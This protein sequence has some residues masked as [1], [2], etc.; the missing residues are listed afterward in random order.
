MVHN[1]VRPK[2]QYQSTDRPCLSPALGGLSVGVQ[3]VRPNAERRKKRA[4]AE[5]ETVV[6]ALEKIRRGADK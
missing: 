1:R 6:V 5:Q 4:N 2:Q 3:Q